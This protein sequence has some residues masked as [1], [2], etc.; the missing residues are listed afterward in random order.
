MEQR[1][2]FDPEILRRYDV[3]GPRYT[4]YPTAPQFHEGFDDRAYAEAAQAANGADPAR[5]LSLYVHV[6]FCDTV[7]FYC[8]CNKVITGNYQRA[9]RYLEYLEREAELQGELFD[10]DRPVGQLHFGGG[11]P[12]YLG[13][14]DLRRVMAVLGR[15]FRLDGSDAR[16]FSIEIDPRA[17]RPGTIP[18]LGELGFNRISLGVQDFDPDV[19][20]AVNRIQPFEVT[21]RAVEQ[22]RD[23]GFESTNFDLIY[24]LPLQ[25]VETYTRTLERALELR[26]ERLA[27]YN[28]AHLPQMFKTQRQIR[29]TD[30]PDA[31]EKLAILETTIDRLTDAGYVYIGMD[32]FALPDDELAEAQRAGTLQRNFQGYSTR[33]EYDL[34]ALGPTAIGKVGATYSQNLRE[35]DAYYARLDAG[36]LPVFRGLKLSADDRLRRDVISELMCHSRIDFAAIEARHGIV[37]GEVFEDALQ[38]LQ[39]MQA[40]GLVRMEEGRLD[41]LPRG[42]LLLRNVA[43]AFDAYLATEGQRRYSRVV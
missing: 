12:T 11:T 42:R 4:S 21:A 15:H 39:G 30:L 1:L 8:A 28:Y 33:A 3:S 23:H 37:F 29:E 32:H 24:G 43:M 13:D 17:V 22:A 35:L 9:Q 5:P 2:V 31:A 40:D 16:E 27:I 14:E 38:R 6:P 7:C 19:Q 34:V 25:T 26:P 41:V 36:R 18:L 20:R 10:A